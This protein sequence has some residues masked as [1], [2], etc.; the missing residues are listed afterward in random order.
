MNQ[1]IPFTAHL[2]M[3]DNA[4]RVLAQHRPA[5]NPLS[6][7]DRD[8]DQRVRMILRESAVTALRWLWKS[9]DAHERSTVAARVAVWLNR[10]PKVS[11]RVRDRE[12]A[13]GL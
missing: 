8:L 2:A 13:R 9:G 11:L 12:K 5:K 3:C 10:D 1:S 7:T 4:A 6:E